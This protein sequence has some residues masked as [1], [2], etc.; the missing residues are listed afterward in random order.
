MIKSPFL[1][2]KNFMSPMECEQ[3][4]DSIDI[5]IPNY[6]H[7]DNPIKT[8][9]NLPLFRQRVWNRLQSYFDIIENYYNVEIESISEVDLEWYPEGCVEESPR[10][11]NSFF[12]GKKWIIK[13][14]YDFTVIVFLK[15]HN[16]S[17]DFD[18][19]FECYGGQLEFSNHAFSINPIRGTAVIFPGNQYF[20]NRTRSPKYGDAFRLRTNIICFDRFDYDKDSYK[21]NYSIW[22][23]DLT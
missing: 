5:S 2:I 21:G 22:F 3:L 4:L 14:D 16:D 6:D 11:E 17:Q 13:N 15:D 23:K 10:C 20:I 18:D 8:V 7:E 9:L 12:N 1:I 19:A